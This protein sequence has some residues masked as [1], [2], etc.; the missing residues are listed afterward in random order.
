MLTLKP[1]GLSEADD[2][3]VLEDGMEIGRIYRSPGAPAG[4]PA[5]FWG[6]LKTPNRPGVDRGWAVDL[7]TAKA[8]F[9]TAWEAA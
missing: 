6:N 9:R 8:A 3:L 7:E 1:S 4:A 2:Y 5:W